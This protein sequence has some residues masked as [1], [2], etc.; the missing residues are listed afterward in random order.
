MA[1]MLMAGVKITPGL[2]P[3]GSWW[4][5]PSSFPPLLSH[6]DGSYYAVSEDETRD[7]GFYES[8]QSQMHEGDYVTLSS[9]SYVEWDH[10]PHC[11]YLWWRKYALGGQPSAHHISRKL[12]FFHILTLSLHFHLFLHER[13]P[14]TRPDGVMLRTASW[15]LTAVLIHLLCVLRTQHTSCWGFPDIKKQEKETYI[16]SFINQQ[17]KALKVDIATLLYQAYFFIALLVI[18]TILLLDTF[19][20]RYCWFQGKHDFLIDLITNQFFRFLF[21]LNTFNTGDSFMFYTYIIAFTNNDM[22]S[23]HIH[24]YIC[25]IYMCVCVCNFRISCV[26]N[27]IWW[28]PSSFPSFNS[29]STFQFHISPH[30]LLNPLLFFLSH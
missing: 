10:D 16:A 28:H 23:V 5:A 22:F 29:W 30:L 24:N 4:G 13:K 15:T 1:S 3:C 7:A 17:S 11:R 25:D 19:L 9:L 12:L 8:S 27:K 21:F 26:C 6:L 2:S 20:V 18:V 14:R